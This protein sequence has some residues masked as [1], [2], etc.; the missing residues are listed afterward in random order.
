[1]A[2]PRAVANAIR[3]IEVLVRRIVSDFPDREF[4]ASPIAAPP[5]FPLHFYA[6]AV[7]ERYVLA[8]GI[9]GN[10]AKI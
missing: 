4:W 8:T 1:M 3:E 7:N 10:V 9:P 5:A 2:T 6:I